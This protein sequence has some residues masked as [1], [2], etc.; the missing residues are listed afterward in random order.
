VVLTDN[1]LDLADFLSKKLSIQAPEDKDIVTG[2]G[3]LNVLE[4]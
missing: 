2:A 4:V 1:T 3:F